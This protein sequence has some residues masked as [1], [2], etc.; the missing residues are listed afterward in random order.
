MIKMNRGRVLRQQG[1][2]DVI[3]GNDGPPKRML[4]HVA[5]L[6][7]LEKS[8]FPTFFNCHSYLQPFL[9]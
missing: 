1:E 8:A 7:I 2:P 3:G 6:E 9:R 5:H 4:I